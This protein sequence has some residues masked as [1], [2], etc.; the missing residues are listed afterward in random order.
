VAIVQRVEKLRDRFCDA[1]ALAIPG[2]TETAPR[3]NRIAANAHLRFPR[4]DNEEFLILL[5]DANIA[6][7]AGS[8]CASGALEPSHV[9]L[10]M[11][12]SAAQAKE[13]VRFSLGSTT[14]EKEIDYAISSVAA[15][16]AR[17]ADACTSA[18]S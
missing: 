1:L 2:L 10:A 14:T 15:I 6:A 7:S 8:S 11:G 12:Q 18:S 17:L 4:V 3:A 16:Y 13:S 9:L 5:D